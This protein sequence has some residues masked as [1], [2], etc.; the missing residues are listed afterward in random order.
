MLIQ[1]RRSQFSFKNEENQCNKKSKGRECL[2][3]EVVFTIIK[4]TIYIYITYI[5]HYLLQ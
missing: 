2:K 3:E 5:L 4:K 1:N